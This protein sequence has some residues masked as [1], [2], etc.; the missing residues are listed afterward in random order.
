MKVTKIS[1]ITSKICNLNC[2]YCYINN[3][4]VQK[5]H[6]FEEHNKISEA[7]KDKS[8]ID[9]FVKGLKRIGQDPA[10]IEAFDLWG[11]EP[12][13]NLECFFENFD[14]FYQNFPN[15]NE[16]TIST[17][18]I[19]NLNKIYDAIN[20]VDDVINKDFTFN[21]QFSIDGP[22][23]TELN[24][25]AN[26]DI[27]IDNIKELIK[28]LNN[29]KLQKLKVN[30]NLH[31]VLTKNI[32]NTLLTQEDVD[33]Y[34]RVLNDWAYELYTLNKNINID[35]APGCPPMIEFPVIEASKQ[36]GEN[37]YNFFYKT[38]NGCGFEGFFGIV[39]K[40]EEKYKLYEEKNNINFEK[41]LYTLKNPI[42]FKN[43]YQNFSRG[44][45]CGTQ[46]GAIKM[47]YDGTLILCQNTIFQHEEND[48]NKLKL[49]QS[50]LYFKNLFKKGHFPNLLTS[51]SEDLEKYFRYYETISLYSFGVKF[52]TI[53]NY[54]NWL[55]QCDLI[56]PI[57]KFNKET[58][59]KHA[60]ICSWLQTCPHADIVESGTPMGRGLNFVKLYCNGTIDLIEDFL[61][62]D[63]KIEVL[64]DE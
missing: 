48:F 63:S 41:I 47:E 13:T 50:D 26:S 33:N 20:I 17:N 45:G 60:I 51:S 23:F 43:N 19:A 38:L 14:Y 44:T 9:N 12:T 61:F 15:V 46:V 42:K 7:L 37:M 18:G 58:M 1:F 3:S 30:F 57:Y 25:G 36:D 28:Q 35:V 10:N 11:Q 31:N 39:G 64:E 32:F 53:L 49:S 24:R 16:C 55:T 56:S 21:I 59:I 4:N 5:S 34:W 62:K 40:L 29:I 22:T 2:D 27:I 52:T 54:M 8:Y 6:Y